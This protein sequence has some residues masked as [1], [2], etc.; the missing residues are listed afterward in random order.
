MN[1]I[2]RFHKQIALSFIIVMCLIPAH[3]SG[4][5]N[6]P[7]DIDC[8]KVVVYKTIDNID[9]KLWVFQPAIHSSDDRSPAIV[10]YFGGGWNGGSPQQFV[11]QCEHLAARGMV[12]MAGG[13]SGCHRPKCPTIHG[14]V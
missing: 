13:K 4:Q 11:N 8:D 10:F 5:R 9:L 14:V 1:T 2:Y 12:A 6:Y 7:P 3:M